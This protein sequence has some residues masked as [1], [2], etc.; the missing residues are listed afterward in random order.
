M[1]I[2]GGTTLFR[3]FY[4][5]TE[6]VGFLDHTWVETENPRDVFHC[7][8]TL[9]GKPDGGEPA[10]HGEYKANEQAYRIAVHCRGEYD[11][12]FI[13][14]YGIDGVCHQMANRFLYPIGRTYYPNEQWRP[15]GYIASSIAYGTWGH[16][17]RR[18]LHG[19]YAE[20]AEKYGGAPGPM[21]KPGT[22]EY[23]LEKLCLGAGAG[24]TDTDMLAAETEITLSRFIGGIS[25]NPIALD[26]RDFIKELY[27]FAGRRGILEPD[28]NFTRRE[29]EDT[30]D[31]VNA[32]GKELQGSLRNEIGVE[33]YKRLNGGVDVLA[34]LVDVERA[35][36]VYTELRK[37][38]FQTGV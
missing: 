15:H 21:M 37:D 17:F 4:Q 9:S 29:I 36:L 13:H 3:A 8:G 2:S 5:P 18:W 19:I 23:A 32:L 12:C 34:D 1:E 16:S 26:Q 10:L 30:F 24:M 35:I 14:P 38:Q 7:I 11:S 31:T 28:R 22:P 33:A 6:T 20:A 25:G 27:A